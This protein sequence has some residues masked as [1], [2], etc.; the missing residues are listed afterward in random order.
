MAFSPRCSSGIDMDRETDNA[1]IIY[2]PLW[3]ANKS[4]R[5]SERQ[6]LHGMWSD[7]CKNICFLYFPIIIH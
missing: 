3:K 7:H 4:S 2:Q 6:M 1:N 5:F